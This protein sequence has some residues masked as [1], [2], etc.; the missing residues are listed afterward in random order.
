MQDGSFCTL[1]GR[2]NNPLHSVEDELVPV[3]V[4]ELVQVQPDELV[5]VQVAELAMKQLD[6]PA[7]VQVAELVQVQLDQILGGGT[8]TGAGC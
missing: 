8:T 4:A 6:E 7:L 3:Q 2:S 1:K 5:L